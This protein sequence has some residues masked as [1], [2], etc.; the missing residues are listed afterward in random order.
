MSFQSGFVILEC[1]AVRVRAR[2]GV[3]VR[4]RMARGVG[5]RVI[6]SVG[7]YS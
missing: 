1:R 7:L 4:V 6:Y 2:A 3:R 5:V